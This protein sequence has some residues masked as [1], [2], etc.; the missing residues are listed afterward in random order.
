MPQCRDAIEVLEPSI[1]DGNSDATT[2]QP[3]LMHPD[4]VEHLYLLSCHTIRI[5]VNSI[6]AVECVMHVPSN[7]ILLVDGVGGNKH[8]AGVSHNGE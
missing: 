8:A 2:C 3:C 4:A 1:E 5:V 7:V 6:P